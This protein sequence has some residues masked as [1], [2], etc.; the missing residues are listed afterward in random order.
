M[1]I[2]WSGGL[3]NYCAYR[4][5]ILTNIE[6]CKLAMRPYNSYKPGKGLTQRF[7]HIE[8]YLEP[9]GQNSSKFQ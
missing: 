3:L 8:F 5:L 2:L 1:V 4:I 9:N 6:L 7:H